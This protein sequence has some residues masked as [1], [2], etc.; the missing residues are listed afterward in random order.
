MIRDVTEVEY[1]QGFYSCKRLIS[2]RMLGLGNDKELQRARG[3]FGK[4]AY[5][6]PSIVEPSLKFALTILLDI[7]TRYFLHSYLFMLCTIKI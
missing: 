2:S 7:N 4:F 3:V 1:G 6:R 5:E